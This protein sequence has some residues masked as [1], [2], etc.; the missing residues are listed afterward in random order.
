MFGG[1]C[2]GLHCAGCGK[3]IPA[4]SVIAII[5]IGIIFVDVLAIIGAI[6]AICGMITAMIYGVF[7]RKAPIVHHQQAGNLTYCQL[8]FLQT[9]DTEWLGL[10]GGKAPIIGRVEDAPARNKAVERYRTSD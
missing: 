6:I 10:T 7:L 5:V 8:K 3:G 4:L 9:G 2:K 1:I